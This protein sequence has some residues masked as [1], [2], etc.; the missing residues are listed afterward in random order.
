MKKIVFI[1]L[2]F[3]VADICYARGDSLNKISLNNAPFYLWADKIK[4]DNKNK[5]IE[6]FGHVYLTSSNYKIYADYARYDE[7]DKRIYIKGNVR[8]NWDSNTIKGDEVL[9]FVKN[10]TGWIKGGEIFYSVPHLYFKGKDIEKTGKQTYYFKDTEVTACDG[11]VPDW[12]FWIKEGKIGAD[13]DARLYNVFFKIK[14]NKVMYL[15]YL[16]LPVLVKRKS[17]FLVPEYVSSSRDGTGIVLPYYQ[18]LSPEE[19]MTFYPGY[20]SKRGP[21]GG[22]EFRFTPNV[23][24]K[25]FFM[26][27]YLRDKEVYK[28]DGDSPSFLQGDGLVRPNKNR[29]WVRGKM[30]GFLV[31]PDT[32]LKLDIDYVSD[33]DFLREYDSGYLGFDSSRDVFLKEFD[34]DIENK[35]SLIRENSMLI[36]R[37]YNLGELYLKVQYLENL[38]YKNHNLDPTKDDT[39]QRLPEVGLNI[40]K[41]PI[42]GGRLDF[43]SQD[44]ID[45]FYRRSSTKGTRIDIYPSI[46]KTMDLYYGTII[47][48][49]SL[50]DTAYFLDSREGSDLDRFENRYFFE[51]D[52]DGFTQ[53]YRIFSFKKGTSESFAIRHI[54]TPEIEYFYRPYRTRHDLPSFDS[55]DS[56]SRAQDITY[57]LTNQFTLKTYSKKNEPVYRDFLRIKFSQTY[58]IEEAGRD[59]DLKEY[60]RRPFTDLRTEYDF[61]P[62]DLISMEGNI[63]F[64]P[65]VK[66]ITELEHTMDL[67][68]QD[69]LSGFVGYDYK[70]KLI[71]DIHRKGQTKVSII[72]YGG[73]WKP[74]NIW[75]LSYSDERDLDLKEDIKQELA[76]KYIHQCWT[77]S[78]LFTHTQ[79]ED[80]V[81]FT[82][83]LGSLGE[84]S[85]GFSMQ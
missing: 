41:T 34:R 55:V 44:T 7:K 59:K 71:N 74:N 16:R 85:Q 79:D 30:D 61:S 73:E 21:Y 37:E 68:F 58:D 47:P 83:T 3:L 17:G 18:V 70:R 54:L 81:L 53:F 75:D 52:I 31:S 28:K 9:V 43:E 10:S 38:K 6:A 76:I 66:G 27:S 82:I 12:S 14:G 69:N 35:D 33:Q 26:A 13:G 2:F 48:K 24:T 80:K 11:K 62:F 67:K 25:G 20:L 40:F 77:L 49:V 19:D 56:I 36:S 4:F 39:P 64:S 32:R 29:Y 15:P 50:R 1:A 65:Y 8:A 51:F 57:S 42:W 46:S 63:W 78:A 22:V 60:P 5:I 72:R 84:V 23:E 45:Y